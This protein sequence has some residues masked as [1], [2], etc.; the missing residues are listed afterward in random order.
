MTGAPPP[1]GPVAFDR[2]MAERYDARNAPLAPISDALHFLARL[3][4]ADLPDAA[5][6]LCVGV[7]T[8]ADILA[9]AHARPGWRFVGVDPSAEMLAV[10][11]DRLAAAGVLDRCEL[12][13][14]DVSAAPEGEAAGFDAALSLLVAH[15]IPREARPG[16]YGAV[17]D[18]LRPGGRFLTAEICADLDAPAFPAQLRDW[19]QVQALMGATPESLAALP[20]MLR[21]RLSVLAPAE[22]DALIAEAGFAAPV[23]FFRAALIRGV[24]ATRR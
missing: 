20:E 1:S 18:R 7:G 3:A 6:A 4:L 8:G 12:I 13:A 14:G 22:T 17:R 24:H 19:A 11:R 5:R 16:F 15:F 10:C 2:A 9:L 23:P 21:D